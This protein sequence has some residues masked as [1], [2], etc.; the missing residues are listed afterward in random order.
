MCS[1]LPQILFFLPSYLQCFVLE[2]HLPARVLLWNFSCSC[3]VLFK[4]VLSLLLFT[5]ILEQGK[6]QYNFSVTLLAE[7]TYWSPSL[8]PFQWLSEKCGSMEIISPSAG[9]PVGLG[10]TT[11]LLLVL[12]FIRKGPITNQMNPLQQWLKPSKSLS[13]FWVNQVTITKVETFTGRLQAPRHQ[14]NWNISLLINKLNYFSTRWPNIARLDSN[15]CHPSLSSLIKA[16]KTTATYYWTSSVVHS[17][18]L[19]LSWHANRQENF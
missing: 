5:T 8:W 1:G 13:C 17:S 12:L 3:R 4:D 16:E 18:L 10:C 14:D 19:C 6:L 2:V 9:A 7:T 15:R 11:V